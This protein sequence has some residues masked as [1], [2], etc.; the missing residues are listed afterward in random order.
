V[1]FR[2]FFNFQMLGDQLNF[3]PANINCFTYVYAGDQEGLRSGERVEELELEI[4]QW[5]HDERSILCSIRE[6][7]HF[8]QADLKVSRDEIETRNICDQANSICWFTWLL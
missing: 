3:L 7:Y 8:K 2:Q 5:S 4:W 1:P 6:S